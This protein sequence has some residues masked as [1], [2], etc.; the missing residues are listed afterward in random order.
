MAFFVQFFTGW[1]LIPLKKGGICK[2]SSGSERPLSGMAVQKEIGTSQPA[3]FLWKL[4]CTHRQRGFRMPQYRQQPLEIKWH[5]LWHREVI[6]LV[7]VPTAAA[8]WCHTSQHSTCSLG[9]S[10]EVRW[11]RSCEQKDRSKCPAGEFSSRFP[12]IE[13]CLLPAS[14]TADSWNIIAGGRK[15]MCC[16]S[17]AGQSLVWPALKSPSKSHLVC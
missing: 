14:A 15:L 1:I 3:W 10:G 17:A 2:K 13:G 7:V 4:K 16:T 9:V 5:S 12:C 11:T 8:R 6:V